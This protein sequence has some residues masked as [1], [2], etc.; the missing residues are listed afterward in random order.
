MMKFY[1]KDRKGFTLIELMI[2]VAII[3]IL[4]AIA[5]PNF[6]R[7]QARARQSEAKELLSTVYSAN[8]AHFAE[9]NTYGNTVDIGYVV[10]GTPKYYA[11]PTVTS[12]GTTSFVATT[13]GNIDTDATVD[14]WTVTQGQR[15]PVNTTNDVTG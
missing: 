7:F 12:A 6:L 4:S 9:N 11:L 10:A 15:A 14:L 13:T 5:V 3:G 2:V 1:Q 8:E